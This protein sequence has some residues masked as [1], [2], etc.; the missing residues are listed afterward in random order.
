LALAVGQKRTASVI[1]IYLVKA[2]ICQAEHRLSESRAALDQAV[3]L[4]EAEGGVRVFVDEGEPLRQ[5]LLDYRTTLAPGGLARVHPRLDYVNHILAAFPSAP[6]ADHPARSPQ[7][8]TPLVEPLSARELEVLQ[9]VAQG[10][11]NAEISAR[12][13]VTLSTIKGHNQRL[14]GKLQAQN[15]TEAVARARALGLL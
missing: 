1:D 11:S 8:N 10:L 3:A 9:L 6:M 7:P 12:L 2:L 5:L 13:C 15:R 4:A 14:F